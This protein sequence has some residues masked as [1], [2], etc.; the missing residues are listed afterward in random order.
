MRRWS[1]PEAPE[2]ENILGLTLRRLRESRG[3]SRKELARRAGITETFLY[4]CERPKEYFVP[5]IGT[6]RKL[7]SAFARDK[8]ERRRLEWDLFFKRECLMAPIEIRDQL[9][10]SKGEA[11][12]VNLISVGQMP[13]PFLSRLKQDLEKVSL[14]KRRKIADEIGLLGEKS[15]EDP[16]RL[17]LDGKV[18]LGRDQV[19]RLGR[20]LK[21]DPNEYQRLADQIPEAWKKYLE[22]GRMGVDVFDKIMRTLPPTE[23]QMILRMMDAYCE[24]RSAKQK[25]HDRISA[26][27]SERKPPRGSKD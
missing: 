15:D 25:R 20:C 18:M 10:A 2:P 13:Y 4:L 16:F 22:P 9:L 24:D 8:E 3:W 23:Q 6:I 17:V 19:A 14:K 5:S 12:S 27:R 21:Q 1:R 11:G 26:L 7:I